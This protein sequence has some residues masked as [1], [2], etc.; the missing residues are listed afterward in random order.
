GADTST[1]EDFRSLYP[2]SPAL[3]H[4]MVDLSSALERQ[5]SALKLLLQLLVNHRSNLPV[6]QIVPLGAVFDVLIQGET[7]PFKG[8]LREEY[9][10]I[11]S[12]YQ[13]VREWLLDK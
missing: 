12:F 10:K 3:L 13:K 9:A 6:G 1:W 2:F 5:R 7:R 4:V 11:S 8:R